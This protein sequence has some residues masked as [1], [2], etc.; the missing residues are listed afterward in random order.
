MKVKS[1]D[2]K[3]LSKISFIHKIE[4]FDI[5]NTSNLN[6]SKCNVDDQKINMKSNCL[7]HI[8]AENIIHKQLFCEELQINTA[9]TENSI[10]NQHSLPY[11]ID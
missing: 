1:I 8:E 6:Q 3:E 4:L 5:D 11:L 10:I 9:E 7:L 2:F